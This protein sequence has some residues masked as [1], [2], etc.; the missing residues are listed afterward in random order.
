M[1]MR[2]QPSNAT[3]P[4]RPRPRRL[5][6]DR[7]RLNLRE[8][9]SIFPMRLFKVRAIA[10]FC[11]IYAEGTLY[12]DNDVQLRLRRVAPSTLG[13]HADLRP[14]ASPRQD[15]G[16]PERSGR[17]AVTKCRFPEWFGERN[18]GVAFWGPGSSKV[19]EAWVAEMRFNT[20]KDGHD[21]MPLRK[22]CG[23]IATSYMIYQQQHNVEG[24]RG[25]RAAT[26]APTYC[27]TTTARSARSTS[28]RGRRRA[29]P[30]AAASRWPAAPAP[31]F[32][33]FFATRRRGVLVLGRPH[34]LVLRHL[35]RSIETPPRPGRF[36][37]TRAASV[38]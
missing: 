9:G 10:A 18:G 24:A 26:P 35:D 22:V 17:A 2:Y 6:P 12:I 32:P 8:D 5:L 16:H 33:H 1:Q 34:N 30:R 23:G 20:T 13:F 36:H 31:R 28:R 4:R 7:R 21:Q 38:L 37:S 15:R 27:G 14:D 19:A 25:G 11:N 3:G 29:A